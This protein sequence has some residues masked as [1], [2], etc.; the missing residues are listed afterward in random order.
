MA[1]AGSRELEL[2][3]FSLK[4]RLRILNLGSYIY[5][6]MLVYIAEMCVGLEKLELN[7]EQVTDRG[8][9]P[10]LTKMTQLKYLDVAACPNFTGLALFECGEFYGAKEL[11]RFVLAL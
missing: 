9:T 5:D 7:S 2:I 4:N 11:K 6:E 8:L 3:F 1:M 10:V